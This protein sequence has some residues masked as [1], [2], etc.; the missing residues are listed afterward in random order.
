MKNQATRQGFG[1]C[2]YWQTARRRGRMWRK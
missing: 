2:W 1:G